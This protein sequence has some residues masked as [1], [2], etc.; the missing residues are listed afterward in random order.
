MMRFTTGNLLEAKVA[1]LVNTV[2]TVG[3]MGKGLALMFKERFPE[4]YTA[5]VKA[6]RTREVQTGQMFVFP[7]EEKS[8]LQ[9]IVNFPTKQHWRL[10]TEIAWVR[11][12]LVA[13]RDTIQ[14]KQISSIALPPL[15]CGNGGLQ[16]SVVRPLVEEVLSGLRAV[17]ILVYEPTTQY[18]DVTKPK[19][20]KR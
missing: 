11:D 17:E 13:L 8:G 18:Q 14:D 20:W 3:V 19:P 2:N 1:A 9:W 4:N 6:C 12:G 5:Y 16:W 7:V 10:P 15:G